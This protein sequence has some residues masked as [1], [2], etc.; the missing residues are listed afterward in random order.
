[1]NNQLRAIFDTNVYGVIIIDQEK[2][3]I[4]NS[5]NSRSNIII[6]GNKIIRSELRDVPKNKTLGNQNLRNY[7]LTIYDLIVKDHLIN[8]DNKME[9]IADQYYESYR[10]LGGSLSKDNIMNDLII[11]ACASIKELDIVI[12]NDIRSML[13]DNA[14]KAYILVNEINKLK[15]PRFIKYEEFKRLLK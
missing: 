3:K 12:S 15:V 4:L 13:S 1:M 8:L 5:L 9:K 6:Y 10:F 7:I 14:V 11:V 2:E